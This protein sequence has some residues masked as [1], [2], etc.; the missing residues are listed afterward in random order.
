MLADVRMSWQLPDDEVQLFFSPEGLV[1][2]APLPDG[3][4]RVVATV[5]EAPPEPSLA[6]VQA[7]LDARGPGASRTHVEEVVWS[8]RFRVGH[9]LADRFRE[10]AVFLCGDAAHV[11]SPAGGQ[12]M[13]TGIQ[14]AANLAW[15]LGLVLRG[16]ASEKILDSYEPERRAVAQGVLTTA[17]RLTRLAT[18]RSPVA[19][20]LRNVLLAVAGRVGRLPRRLAANLA[21]ID[22]VYRDGWSLDGSTAVERWAPKHA[23]VSRG[24]DP[25]FGLVVPEGH[26]AGAAVDAARF[27][28]VPVRIVPVPGLQEVLVVRPD[29]Y[30][31]GRGAPG[32]GARLLSLLV[33]ALEAKP[34]RTEEAPVARW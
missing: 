29:G 7:L 10:G 6:D 5:D 21:E 3:R 12:G 23:C 2:V 11:H 1:V 15:K 13:K 17:H 26:E 18:M 34:R 8:S 22:I 4:H 9:K 20:R 16:R 31:A 30:V 33:R 27:P 14:D 32:E 25:A 28:G 19:R 24:V